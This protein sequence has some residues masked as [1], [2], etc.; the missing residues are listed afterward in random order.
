MHSDGPEGRDSQRTPLL[1]TALSIT[2]ILTLT[3]LTAGCSGSSAPN[4][5]G[6]ARVT[7]SVAASGSPLNPPSSAAPETAVAGDIPDNVAYV[8][9]ASNRGHYS[10]VHPEGWATLERGTSVTITDKLNGVHASIA[11]TAGPL[12]SQSAAATIRKL[13]HDQ[14]GFELI[15]SGFADVPSGRAIQIVFRRSGAFDTVTGK[16]VPE[17]VHE[18][19]IAAAPGTL[20]LDLYGAVGADNVD[21][22]AKILQSVQFS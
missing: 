3:G 2:C 6:E 16:S 4:N 14:P 1:G 13:R 15:S 10:F 11:A 20:T 21:P 8:R 22:Y 9:F 12:N 18:Y 5:T 17:E 7:G 19:I